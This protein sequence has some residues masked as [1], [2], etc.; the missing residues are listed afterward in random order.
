[1]RKREP[2]GKGMRSWELRVESKVHPGIYSFQLQLSK[3]IMAKGTVAALRKAL[4]KE[5]VPEETVEMLLTSGGGRVKYISEKLDRLLS[6]IAKKTKRLLDDGN[7]PTYET[8]TEAINW[9]L[10]A[11]IKDSELKESTPSSFGNPKTL[12]RPITEGKW[13]P[14][15][16][17]TCTDSRDQEQTLLVLKRK[18]PAPSTTGL[19]LLAGAVTTENTGESKD[20]ETAEASPILASLL[21]D[22]SKTSVTEN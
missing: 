17:K 5:G 4:L 2:I 12:K 3:D 1:M 14:V 22:E 15:V 7:V 18:E 20:K 9:F 8:L 16:K 19:N 11:A 13:V 10:F 21:Q 6:W